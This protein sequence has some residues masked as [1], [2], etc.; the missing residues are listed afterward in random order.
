MCGPY[1][2][3]VLCG[4]YL[5]VVLCGV[6][7]LGGPYLEV[8]LCGPYLEVVLCG[9]YLE[10]V[11][12]GVEA[13]GGP[14][15]EVVL[16]GPYLEVVLCGVE[17]SAALVDARVRLVSESERLLAHHARRGVHQHHL[18][19]NT[20]NTSARNADNENHVEITS[21]HGIVAEIKTLT[22]VSAIKTSTN[23]SVSLVT[24]KIDHETN[25][26]VAA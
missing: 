22:S 5:E 1:L 19:A 4:P 7:A 26:N 6:E 9:P 25:T 8:V 15:L 3:V 12:C 2:E 18:A 17:A 11:L 21:T 16:C 23:D 20:R 10:V 13:L 14:Y 24:G